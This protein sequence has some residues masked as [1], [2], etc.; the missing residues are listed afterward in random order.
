[1]TKPIRISWLV[2]L[3]A[4]FVGCQYSSEPMATSPEDY[5][6]TVDGMT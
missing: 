4:A 3:G 2:I 5:V 1:M 6:L